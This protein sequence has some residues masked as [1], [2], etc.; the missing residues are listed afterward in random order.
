MTIEDAREMYTKISKAH[1]QAR[2]LLA[3]NDTKREAANRLYSN[4]LVESG[5]IIKVD[6]PQDIPTPADQK[7]VALI[8]SDAK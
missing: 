7:G 2:D 8:M 3:L 6:N 4:E 1:Q 5:E